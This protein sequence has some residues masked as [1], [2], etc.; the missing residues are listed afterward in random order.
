MWLQAE[1][2]IYMFFTNPQTSL[3]FTGPPQGFMMKKIR[4]Y[5]FQTFEDALEVCQKRKAANTHWTASLRS[6]RSLF[7]WGGQ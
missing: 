7:Q 2:R 4:L 5:R 3:C 1:H 6:F